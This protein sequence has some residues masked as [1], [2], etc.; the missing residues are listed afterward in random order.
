MV[1]TVPKHS[2]NKTEEK[3]KPEVKAESAATEAKPEVSTATAENFAEELQK[4]VEAQ[5]QKLDRLNQL[6]ADRDKFMQS[7]TKVKRYCSELKAAIE[8]NDIESPSFRLIFYDRSNPR[9]PEQLG[10]ANPELLRDFLE[11]LD[12]KV[13]S[14]IQQINANIVMLAA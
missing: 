14:K 3:A 8:S 1:V 11:F 2:D 13:D 6:F 10:I 12:Q 7:K 4:K 5:M 9:D